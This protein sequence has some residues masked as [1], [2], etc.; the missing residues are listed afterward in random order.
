MTELE[1]LTI[2]H[3]VEF[4]VVYRLGPGPKGTGGQ[5]YLYSGMSN[6][7]QIPVPADTILV[8]HTHPK[9]LAYPSPADKKLLDTF[10]KAGSPMRSSQII[11]VGN[12]GM[13]VTFTKRGVTP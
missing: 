3:G 12:G 8:Y 11:P 1:N 5:Y 13:V 9:G 7:V 10:E 4:A 6:A 2:K